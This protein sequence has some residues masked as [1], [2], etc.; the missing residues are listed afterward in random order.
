[1]ENNQTKDIMLSNAI[2]L[3]EVLNVDLYEL[4]C[5]EKQENKNEIGIFKRI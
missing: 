1:M 2:I 5:I 3:S 4:F